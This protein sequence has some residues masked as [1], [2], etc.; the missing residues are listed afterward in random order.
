MTNKAL[1]EKARKLQEELKK[2][3]EK[4]GAIESTSD[5]DRM[6]NINYAIQ[7]MNEVIDALECNE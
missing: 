2:H 5:L 6:E 1:L 7:Q 4:L 3:Y